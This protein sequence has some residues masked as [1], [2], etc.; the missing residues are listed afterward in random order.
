MVWFGDLLF[1]VVRLLAVEW[2]IVKLGEE[3]K[4]C[5]VFLEGWMLDVC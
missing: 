5:E 2:F 1:G 3:M 4:E